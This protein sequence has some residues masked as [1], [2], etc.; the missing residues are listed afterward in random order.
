[1]AERVKKYNK[2]FPVRTLGQTYN[3]RS[4]WIFTPLAKSYME[5][6]LELYDVE[7]FLQYEAPRCLETFKNTVTDMRKEA[8]RNK[9]SEKSTTAKP[10]GNS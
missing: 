7:C 4:I 9:N 5:L 6:G 1:M 10:V 8:D 3:A 2:K